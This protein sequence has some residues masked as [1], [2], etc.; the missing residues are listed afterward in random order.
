MTRNQ[1]FHKNE[2]RK[3]TFQNLQ[4]N[5]WMQE[6]ILLF[7]LKKE[8]VLIKVMYLKQKKKNQKKNQKKNHKKKSQKRKD[9]YKKFII[10]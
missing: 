9:D 5:C 2:K 1:E 7:F 8:L 3:I 10:Y 6:K 4:E